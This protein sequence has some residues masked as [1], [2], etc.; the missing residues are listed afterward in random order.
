MPAKMDLIEHTVHWAKGEITEAIAMAAFGAII[1]TSAVL[2]WK[3]G[4]TP[5]SKALV[6]PLLVV[7]AIPLLMGISGAI[8][9]QN[10]LPEFRKAW[11]QNPEAFVQ[12]EKTRVEG[13]DQ[14][15]KYSYP[16]AVILTVGGAVLFFLLASPQWKAVSLAV[17]TLGLMAYFIDHFAAERAAIYLKHI[18]KALEQ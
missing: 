13:F 7:G 17:M 12:Q 2:L 9:N 16:G 1:V 11:E 6:V 8:S 18:H 14:I 5:Y 3:L 10:R 4:G 15:F